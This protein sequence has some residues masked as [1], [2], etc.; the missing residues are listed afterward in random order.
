LI[1]DEAF[2]VTSDDYRNQANHGFPRRNW[3]GFTPVIRRDP[4]SNVPGGSYQLSDLPPFQLNDLIPLL[5]P[6]YDAA[7]RC[8]HRYVDLIKEQHTVWPVT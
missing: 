2:T 1:N 7:I 6:Q 5:E 3:Y 4:L 8:Y